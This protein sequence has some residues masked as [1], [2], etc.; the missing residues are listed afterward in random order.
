MPVALLDLLL[1]RVVA[2]SR[3]GATILGLDP[4]AVGTDWRSVI[5]DAKTARRGVEAIRTGSF[6]AYQ[7]HRSFRRADGAL[8]ET[9]VWVRVVDEERTLAVV[10]FVEPNGSA[11]TSADIGTAVGMLDETRCIQLISSDVTHLL[12]YLP[13]VCV[14]V[15][16][17]SFVHP[18]DVAALREVFSRVTSDK[19]N[20][21]INVRVRAADGS[22]RPIH[23]TLGPTVGETTT[24]GFAAAR[25]ERMTVDSGGAE[26]DRI[27]EL[28]QHLIRVAREVE[29][30]GLVGR[31]GLIPDPSRVPELGDLTSRQWQILARLLQGE[32][33]PAIA[34]A[35]YL[36]PS[37]VRNHLSLIY[38]KLGV[39]SQ[40]EL[41]E[42]LQPP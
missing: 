32:R 37:T 34:A 33:V 30:A 41:I 25:D 1:W 19:T 38:K 27:A 4:S 14:G 36:S 5:V 31:G 6:D 20:I 18:S 10:I 24:F 39:H 11:E 23:L 8:I 21:S 3:R 35:I 15:C 13:E 42:K 40:A 17:D 16:V 22:W 12:G 28:E 7:A 29:A 26:A 9:L 2:I